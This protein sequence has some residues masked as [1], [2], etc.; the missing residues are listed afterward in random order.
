[1]KLAIMESI[2]TPGGHEVDFDRI[3]VEE[4]RNLNHEVT[5]VVPEKFQFQRDYGV[6]VLTLPGKVVSYEGLSG[7]RKNLASVKREWNRQKWFKALYEQALEKKFDAVIIPTSTYR[8]LRA[9]R[10][11]K[12]KKSPIPIVFIVHGVNPKEESK[13]FSAA[14][15]LEQYSNIKVLVLTFD[16]KVLGKTAPNVNCIKPPTYIPRDIKLAKPISKKETL[17]LGFFGQ[18]RRE[19]NLDALLATILS[20]NFS[21]PVKLSIQGATVHPADAADFERIIKKYEDNSNIEFLHKGLFGIEWQN[22][23]NDIDVLLMP[24]ASERYLYHWAGM[25]FTAL[26]FRKTVVA[27]SVINPEVFK[28]YQIGATFSN[29][30]PDD[31]KLVLEKFVNTYFDKLE[32]YDKELSRAYVDFNPSSFVQQVVNIIQSNG[33]QEK[34]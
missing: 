33:V 13:F 20:C 25:L 4:L 27:S 5:F 3:L 23:I 26:G 6:T 30:K 12:L 17:K 32:L 11:S 19:K 10:L 28:Q 16:N 21:I 15:S 24:Y 9:L 14:K 29:E 2:M 7:L 31:L 1:M 8:Y 18:Y 22:A 34:I